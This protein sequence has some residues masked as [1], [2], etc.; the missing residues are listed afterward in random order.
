MK[1]IIALSLVCVLA[2]AAFCSSGQSAKKLSEV[3][4]E[5]KSEVTLKDFDEFKSADD[6]NRFYGFSADDVEE[7]AGG[8]NNTGVN[9]EEIVLVKAKDDSAASKVKDALDN[10]Y[11]AKLNENKNYNPEQAKIIEK[12]KVES[13]GV[14][15]SMIVSE[16]ADKI[17]EIFKKGI[18]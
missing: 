17:T 3:F 15:V 13:D 8:V 9:Q 14:Y 7:Y 18:G 2:I 10:R 4:T 11:K 16:N 5:I 12:C 1:R 6:L